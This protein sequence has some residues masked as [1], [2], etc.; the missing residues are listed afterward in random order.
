[1]VQ[2]GDR[3]VGE[4]NVYKDGI[5][6]EDVNVVVVETTIVGSYRLQGYWWFLAYLPGPGMRKG[7]TTRL[8]LSPGNSVPTSAI[9]VN[10]PPDTPSNALEL[11]C[12]STPR[13]CFCDT[14]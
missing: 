8:I 6:D 1:M 11:L 5:V 14:T 3:L 9:Q 7:P 4:V 12:S 2:P 10:R 13:L